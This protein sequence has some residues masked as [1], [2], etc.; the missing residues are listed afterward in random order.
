[1]PFYNYGAQ[2]DE[3]PPGAN[4]STYHWLMAPLHHAVL[5]SD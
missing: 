1:M 5:A 3:I 4:W 2:V